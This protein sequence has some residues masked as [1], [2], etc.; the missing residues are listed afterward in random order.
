MR[1]SRADLQREIVELKGQL[2]A[3][4][5]FANKDLE[6]AGDLPG[7]GVLL[8]LCALGGRE[9]IKPIVIRDGLSLESIAALRAD[10]V[11]SFA[12]ATAFKPS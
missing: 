3:S 5:Y 11:R 12:G 9:I 7:S 2:A 6:K 1:N 10:L 4:Y 8:M